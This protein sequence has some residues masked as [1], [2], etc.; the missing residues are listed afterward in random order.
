[1]EYAA[2]FVVST[3]VFCTLIGS[4]VQL[5]VTVNYFAVVVQIFEEIFMVVNS[6]SSAANF[7][8]SCYFRLVGGICVILGVQEMGGAVRIS[9]VI[10]TRRRYCRFSCTIVQLVGTFG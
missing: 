5:D 3:E 7:V 2:I 10:M 4:W 6:S 8:V 9:F 1:M